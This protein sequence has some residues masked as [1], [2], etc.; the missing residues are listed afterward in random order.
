MQ[1]SLEGRLGVGGGGGHGESVV[2]RCDGSIVAGGAELRR[3]SV[4]GCCIELTGQRR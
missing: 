3:P 1:A 2:S 4:Y